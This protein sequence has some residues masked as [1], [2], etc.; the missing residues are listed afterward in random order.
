[1]WKYEQRLYITSSISRPA[2]IGWQV[3]SLFLIE[4]SCEETECSVGWISPPL[5]LFE[6]SYGLVRGRVLNGRTAEDEMR[7]EMKKKFKH[8]IINKEP[9][10]IHPKPTSQTSSKA[11]WLFL[12][13][14]ML[15][16]AKYL[17]RTTRPR[18]DPEKD[19][20]NQAMRLIRPSSLFSFVVSL[21][22]K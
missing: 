21:F 5:R 2:S 15:E 4:P 12:T 18:P 10:H 16:I 14:A 6:S 13:F 17:R 1:M 22:E 11:P 19:I 9:E 3:P 20:H 8:I 7:W